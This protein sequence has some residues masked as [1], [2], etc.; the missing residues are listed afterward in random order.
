MNQKQLDEFAEA[1]A[2]SVNE[3]INDKADTLI[4]TVVVIHLLSIFCIWYFS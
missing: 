2:Q 4:A 1:I 3:K